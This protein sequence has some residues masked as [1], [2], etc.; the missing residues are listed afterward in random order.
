MKK[1][2]VLAGGGTKGIYQAGV[3][4]ALKEMQ[5]DD[6]NIITGTSVG[7]LNAAMLVQGDYDRMLEMYENLSAEQIIKGFVPT[8]D[9]KI[10]TLFRERDMFVDS[11]KGWIKEHGVD[12]E[13]FIEMVHEYYDEDKFFASDIDFGCI[14]AT[15]RGHTGVYV[16]K[17]MM[18]GHGEDWLIASAAAS[19]V[20]P[21][22]EIEG[23]EYVD[24]GYFDNFPV[25]FALRLGA[26]EII[27]IDLNGEPIH[28]Q[29]MRRKHITYIHPHDDL[30]TFLDFDREKLAHAKRIGYLDAMKAFHRCMGQ[31]YAF[32]LFELPS[33]FDEWYRSVLRLE[34]K[35]KL[36]NSINH[37]R[38][39]QMITDIL[40]QNMH[41]PYLDDA[42]YLF[43]MMDTVM[44]MMG[45]QEEVIHDFSETVNEIEACFKEAADED[46]AILPDGN[47]LDI[48]GYARTLD[49]KGIV[50]KLLHTL[51]YPEHRLLKDNL[52][53]SVYPFE[54]AIAEFIFYLMK[55]EKN[56]K[57]R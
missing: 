15:N 43:G 56:G 41:L 22:K 24:G 48:A 50:T 34:A 29:Y 11:F 39:E 1:A 25:D 9:T 36:A 45:Y 7:A 51:F 47:V 57:S 5:M 40:R 26:E 4:E 31:K 53:L 10:S 49:R 44:D 19:P 27:A 8:P 23:I 35:I 55:G 30:Y 16:T 20:F 38:S 6:W 52:I 54:Q 12:I 18:R 28:P 13:P 21:V 14:T 46:Y 3:I 32:Y 17:E 2:L 33:F 37:L 42:D